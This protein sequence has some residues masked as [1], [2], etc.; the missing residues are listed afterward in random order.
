[1]ANNPN[2]KYER[3]AFWALPLDAKKASSKAAGV[4]TEAAGTVAE[5][6]VAVTTSDGSDGAVVADGDEGTAWSPE[7]ADGSWL[8]LSFADAREVADVEVAGENLPEGTRILLSE[9]ADA[10]TDEVP[11]RARYVWVLFPA[12]DEPPAVK[13]IRVPSV[14]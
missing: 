10:W 9:D 1:M 3:I 5:P 8:V 2:W 4:R 6:P 12:S 13:E 7:T 14:R 11:C